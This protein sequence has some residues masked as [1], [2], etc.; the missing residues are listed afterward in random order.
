[1]KKRIIAAIIATL[2]LIILPM[3]VCGPSMA[4]AAEEAAGGEL[5][6]SSAEYQGPTAEKPDIEF[7]IKKE[8]MTEAEQKLSTTMLQLTNSK[9]LPDGMSQNDLISQMK[10]MDQITQMPI[11]NGTDGSASGF[12]VYVYIKLNEGENL[13]VLEPYISRMVDEDAD[14]G[15]AAAWVDQSELSNIAALDAVHSIRE[16]TAPVFDTGSVTS[17]GDAILQADDVRAQTGTDGSG[18]KVGIISNG[19]DSMSSAVATGDLPSDVTVL[20]NAIGGDEGTAMLEIVHD[21]APGAQLYFHDAGDNVIAFCNA[22]D[23]LVSA[24]CDV[25]CDDVSWVT[26]PFFE[27]GTIAQHVDAMLTATDVVYVS[28][29]G[30]Y[31][32]KHYQGAFYNDGSNYNDFSEGSAIR[33]IPICMHIFRQAVRFRSFCS[34]MSR[35]AAPEAIMILKSMIS[36]MAVWLLKARQTKMVMMILRNAVFTLTIPVKR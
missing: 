29:A 34:G 13:I 16:V 25:I 22:I 9:Y 21:L 17:E 19:V 1:M 33:L 27:D 35:L 31:A 6:Q 10:D 20:S 12:E 7:L 36:H 5:P 26:E 2:L 23:A 24:G 18:I 14:I 32:N 11:V 28:S 30:N 4:L 15:L 3:A 8:G